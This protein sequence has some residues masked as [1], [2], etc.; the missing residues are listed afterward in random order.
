LKHPECAFVPYGQQTS[1]ICTEFTAIPRRTRLIPPDL[2]DR[3][4]TTQKRFSFAGST[5]GK[6]YGF[7]NWAISLL[8][9]PEKIIGFGR[10]SIRR[11]G[12]MINN[13]GYRF[14]TDAGKRPGY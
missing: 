12:D 4:L 8:D 6:L 13:L 1:P 7:G 11:H 3:T 14:S 2:I 5:T 10:L 9:H